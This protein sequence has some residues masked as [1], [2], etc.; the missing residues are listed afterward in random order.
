MTSSNF[1][2]I[3]G[4]RVVTLDGGLVSPIY[5]VLDHVVTSTQGTTLEDVFH[6]NI[7]HTSLWS[8]QPI[9]ENPEIIVQ[10]HLAFL[11][12]GAR[13]ISA[14]TYQCAY[15][16]FGRSGYS[17]EDAEN[18][19]TKAVQ[20]AV[21]AKKRFLQ[22]RDDGDSVKIALSFGP[23]GATLNPAQ[24]FDGFYPTPYGPRAYSSESD[25]TNSFAAGEEAKEEEAIAALAQFHLRRLLVFAKQPDTW[26]SFD[27]LAFETVPLIREVKGIRRAVKFLY[28]SQLGLERKPWWISTVWP[29]GRYPQAKL[30]DGQPVQPQD[31]VEALLGEGD[32]LPS[33]KAFGI[34]CTTTFFLPLLLADVQRKVQELALGYKPWLVLYPNGGDTYDPVTQTW[35][36]SS[37]GKQKG[38]KWA[39]QVID[40]VRN[41]SSSRVWEGIIA[42][43]CCRTGPGEIERLAQSITSLLDKNH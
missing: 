39:G 42:G 31:V 11:R 15:E 7:C 19:M 34:N 13:V 36:E 33:P 6:Q 29:E 2:S 16:T 30:L 35:I 1:L 20:L 26:S 25:N 32:G 9:Q 23:F 38:E 14:S 5:L 21:E 43:G 22:D 40:A 8:A 41:A 27:C 3:F 17:R 24:E 4:K 10:A 18:T 12:A 28:E 37:S